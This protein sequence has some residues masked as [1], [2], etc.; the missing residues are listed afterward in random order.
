M[1]MKRVILIFITSIIIPVFVQAQ[2]TNY[3]L[4]KDSWKEWDELVQ[5]IRLLSNML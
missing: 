2:D 5:K 3:C 4:N 1:T